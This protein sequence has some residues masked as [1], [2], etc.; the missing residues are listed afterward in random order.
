[1]LTAKSLTPEDRSRLEGRIAFVAEKAGI[2]LPVLARRLA[3]VASDHESGAG[4]G[5]AP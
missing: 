5:A 4:Q 3:A 2:D 1:V